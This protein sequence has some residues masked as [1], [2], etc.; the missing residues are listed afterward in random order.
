MKLWIP[1]G[2]PIGT[3]GTDPACTDRT[4]LTASET[5]RTDPTQSQPDTSGLTPTAAP[6][7][8]RRK[9]E[10][11]WTRNASATQND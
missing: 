5:T 7:L 9:E 2:L 1:A 6:R 3:T 11:Q 4:R 10:L 8:K